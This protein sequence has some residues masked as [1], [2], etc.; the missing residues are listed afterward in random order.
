MKRLR[1]IVIL[2]L[3]A[4]PAWCAKK[5]TVGEL[6]DSLATMHRENRSDMEVANTLKQVELSEQLNRNT[7]NAMAE[8]I[9][10]P[11]S[12][13]Q[14]YVLEARSAV[15]A[16]PPSDLPATPPLD[17]AA[18]KALLDKTAA[19]VTAAYGK[20]PALT[21]TKST[22]RFQNNLQA[23]APSSGMHS[24]SRD[25][26]VGSA[27]ASSDQFIRFVGST[28]AQI[29]LQNGTER[30]MNAKDKT[31][32]GRNGEIALEGPGPVLATVFAEAQGAGPINWLRWEQVNGKPAVVF[33][34]A[35][36]RKKSHYAVNYCCFPDV[37]QTGTVKFSGPQ[38]GAGGPGPGPVK[39]NLQFNTDWKNYKATVGY[40]GELF[41]DPD[42]GIVVRLITIAEFKNTEVVQQE[43]Q[44]FDYHAVTVGGKVLVLPIKNFI[45]TEVVPNGDSGAGTYST[46]CTLFA[47]EY[48]NYQLADVA[49][50]K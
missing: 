45:I 13:E 39:G 46:R 35:V 1:W 19:Y 42:T 12:T 34:F 31:P 18:Q 27:L 7:M 11:L 5:M 33:S 6:R 47:S 23:V 16:P 8:Y 3:A 21:A 26:S 14:V 41:V 2:A 48:K 28:D 9:P 40:H 29:E 15:L 49:A 50:Q 32:W 36:P 38:L 24:S 20:Q 43:D 22:D 10:G 25:V 44:R 17:A 4:T 37:D 30:A